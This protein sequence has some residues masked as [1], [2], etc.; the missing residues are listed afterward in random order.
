VLRVSDRSYL[1]R[2]GW[3]ANKKYEYEERQCDRAD[4][5]SLFSDQSARRRTRRRQGDGFEA[6]QGAV[7]ALQQN[8]GSKPLS[9][10]DSDLSAGASPPD[11]SRRRLV[12]FLHEA[13]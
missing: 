11:T 6:G 2:A 4:A 8:T 5:G 1:S 7:H 10:A 13:A 9:T 12:Q 3:Q